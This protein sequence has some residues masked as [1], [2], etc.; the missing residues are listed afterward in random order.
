MRIISTYPLDSNQAHAVPNNFS[1]IIELVD[2]L[3][4]TTNTTF[5]FVAISSE[6]LYLTQ[7]C[8]EFCRTIQAWIAKTEGVLFAIR[9]DI[10]MLRSVDKFEK[11]GIH[12]SL[13]PRVP[14]LCH[15]AK[16]SGRPGSRRVYQVQRRSFF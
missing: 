11:I 12:Q 1:G 7:S 14:H 13:V 10:V 9:K 3:A 5:P 4:V 16:R 6:E 2:T 15:Q 8:S